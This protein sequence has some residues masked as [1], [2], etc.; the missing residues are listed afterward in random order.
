M[1]NATGKK[2]KTKPAATHPFYSKY[3]YELIIVAFALL[4]YSNSLFND[5]NMDDELVTR[6]HRLTSK[7]IS[8]VPEIFSSPYYQD[9]AGYAYEYR[10]VSLS[11]FAIEHSL[12]GDNVFV[13]HMVN[14]LLYA[15]LCCCLFRLLIVFGGV[16]T[17]FVAV[18]IT[19]LFCAHPSHSEV[20]CSIKNR[21]EIL[22]LIFCILSCLMG[23]VGARKKQW[24]Y[25][26]I[27]GVL[28]L[29][30]MLCKK[31]FLPFAFFIPLA[32]VLFTDAKL[33]FVCTLTTLL[34]ICMYVGLGAITPWYKFWLTLLQ[35]IGT[36]VF[37]FVIRGVSIS[38]M[39][40]FLKNNQP[41]LINGEMPFG[42]LKSW[43]SDFNLNSF[44]GLIPTAI[45]VFF[46]LEV[47]MHTWKMLALIPSLL[48]V[49][50]YLRYKRVNFWS[51]GLL[52]SSLFLAI[53]LGIY[54]KHQLA[55]DIDL[56]IQLNIFYVCLFTIFFWGHH[57]LRIPAL[58]L[59]FFVATYFGSGSIS[60]DSGDILG[61][62]LVLLFS[63]LAIGRRI[64]LASMFILPVLFAVV[65]F[66]AYSRNKPGGLDY[67][68]AINFISVI[69]VFSGK[70][71]WRAVGKYFNRGLFIFTIVVYG[72]F[73]RQYNYN[74]A[75]TNVAIKDYGKV[76]SSVVKTETDRPLS[77]VEF[78]VTHDSPLSSR[79]G[80]ALASAG[81]YLQK[82]VLSYPQSF[83]YGFAFI[84][85]TELQ[86]SKSIIF[87]L[88]HLA[89]LLLI[90]GL[91][92]SNPIISFGLIIYL[93][94]V[95]VFSG[96]F[97][98]VPGV[99]ADRYLLIPSLGW[100]IVFIAG[101]IKIN[102]IDSSI[103]NSNLEKIAF[104]KLPKYFRYIFIGVLCSYS[105]LTFSRN[106]DW[107]DD[108][109]LF[110]HDIDYVN[111]S[112]Q[113][114][115]LLALHLMQHS[116]KEQDV[117]EKTNLQ[118]E[119][120]VHFKKALEIYP[121]FFNVAYDIGRV[122][123]SLSLPDSAIIAFKQALTIDTSFS[124]VHRYIGELY[125]SQG[126][127]KE[128]IPYFEHVISVRSTESLG[129]D[130]LSFIYYQLKEYDKSVAV[131][132]D[133][134]RLVPNYI[135][136]YMNIGR[137]YINMNMK[138]SATYYLNQ[139]VQMNPENP[140]PRQLLQTIS[141]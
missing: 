64:L 50:L 22:G 61:S 37:Y 122:Y 137:T 45:A 128:A 51:L 39:R 101:L 82:T 104:S 113:A 124:E 75:I 103:L 19:L 97:V 52:L 8:G 18:C 63:R 21:D 72:I 59:V 120:L 88:L 78:P 84:K 48:I 27:V 17:P 55:T 98:P 96:F 69:A 106:L 79:I 99:V 115:N 108:L 28:F 114:H 117:L 139:A 80:T 110:R 56:N 12:F 6:N 3:F 116:E 60:E 85:P 42:G 53:E 5:Y 140:G 13:S 1:A 134:I 76:V 91:L 123:T 30:A 129:Y 36:I 7:G 33:I 68:F 24:W 93:L 25:V 125:F 49:S 9:E 66:P 26:P 23:I 47:C 16:I 130:K 138:D 29:G 89:I 107:K 112:A 131:N 10:P 121:Y 83:Y 67:T 73:A 58:F 65:N 119:A 127:L 31:T 70:N 44:Y 32:I 11:T 71:F 136:G 15:F 54:L 87:L 132:K 86:N 133:G 74:A 111:S 62:F 95:A 46:Y 105:L 34:G 94:S 141:K 135:D 20:V 102:K 90:I 4:L 118:K 57:S 81:F 77:F 92:R 14:C 126:K 109:T 35:I 38:E 43:F 40:F 2:N 100:S 41:E